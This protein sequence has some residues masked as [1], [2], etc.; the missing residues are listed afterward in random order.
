MTA[1]EAEPAQLGRTLL[2]LAEWLAD[3]D[4][5]QWVGRSM[6]A[7][8]DGDSRYY[9]D[10]DD[11]SI[12]YWSVTHILSM[13]Q[14]KTYLEKWKANTAARATM[15]RNEM[16]DAILAFGTEDQAVAWAALEAE[17]I[18]SAAAEAG[19]H[20]HDVFEALLLGRPAPEPPRWLIGM[21]LHDEPITAEM[22]EVWGQGLTNFLDDFQP[23]VELA[24][25]TV[26]HPAEDVG[27][28]VD[29]G[30]VL[31]H[32]GRTLGD[33]KTGRVVDRTTPLQLETYRQCPEIVLPL[34]ERAAMPRY[35]SSVVIH[36]RREYGRGYKVL[37]QPTGRKVWGRFLDAKR[38]F[39][40]LQDSPAVGR[41]A[42]YP[43]GRDD[44]GVAVA[45]RAFPMIEDVDT[46]GFPRAALLRS[47]LCTW[48][49]E[50]AQYRADQLLSDP[51]ARGGVRRVGP[52]G[53]AAIRLALGEHGLTLAGDEIGEV[54]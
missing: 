22:L 36:L 29:V 42:W 31:P 2:D 44:A 47:E 28:T 7:Q 40:N 52:K 25:A 50:L 35:D 45:P 4:T 51:K 48:L 26:L 32:Y 37:P 20:L 41:R 34:G 17:R 30:M 6:T 14:R 24:E 21:H 13:T 43:P 8:E 49:D 39:M 54:A 38:H 15:R 19:R 12:R 3:P 53:L 16:I 46:P 11:P 10:P 1:V 9:E 5:P 18:R 33:L 23:E 27:G